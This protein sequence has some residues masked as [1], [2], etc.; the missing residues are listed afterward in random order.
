M[1]R[2]DE[3]DGARSSESGKGRWGPVDGEEGR[4]GRSS[5]QSCGARRARVVNGAGTWRR[6]Q[7][8]ARGL[9]GDHCR[10]RGDVEATTRESLPEPVRSRVLGKSV[11]SL[12]GASA[13]PLSHT[14]LCAE[15]APVTP[16]CSPPQP[17]CLLCSASLRGERRR[18]LTGHARGTRSGA[19]TLTLRLAR[20]RATRARV[21]P[22]GLVDLAAHPGSTY[23]GPRTCLPPFALGVAF[24]CFCIS[25]C[26]GAVLTSRRV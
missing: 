22:F 15:R 1:E 5:G 6:A 24:L 16:V 2:K 3:Q 19:A 14:E 8:Q 17:W 18:E 7:W 20:H 11:N 26:G 10:K 25:A 23:F 21:R 9:S 13:I 4:T 12:K